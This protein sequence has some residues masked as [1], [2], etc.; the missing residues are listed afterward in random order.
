MVGDEVFTGTSGSLL[1]QPSEFIES[2]NEADAIFAGQTVLNRSE[3][4][5]CWRLPQRKACFR[6]RR[7]G[8]IE[9]REPSTVCRTVPKK[10]FEE[11]Q[12]A[13][14]DMRAQV[15]TGDAA[16]EG[17]PWLSGLSGTPE[18]RLRCVACEAVGGGYD[19]AGSGVCLRRISC[20]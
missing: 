5:R 10:L 3:A 17:A 14:Q 19:E 15:A 4:T 12:Q 1:L 13:T 20:R 11:P 18:S 16:A 9:A 7:R 8:C 2:R 6:G